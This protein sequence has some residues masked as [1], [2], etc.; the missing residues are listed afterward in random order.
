[1]K[2]EPEVLDRLRPIVQLATRVLAHR[3]VARGDEELLDRRL[4]NQPRDHFDFSSLR[5]S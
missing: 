1:M 4:V 5:V 3:S 2:L